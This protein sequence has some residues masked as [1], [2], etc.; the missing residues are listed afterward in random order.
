MI[1]LKLFVNNCATKSEPSFLPSSDMHETSQKAPRAP[2]AIEK[3][4]EPNRCTAER[5]NTVVRDHKHTRGRHTFF[6]N[7]MIITAMNVLM[8]FCTWPKAAVKRVGHTSVERSGDARTYEDEHFRNERV[9]ERRLRAVVLIPVQPSGSV[10][11]E[12]AVHDDL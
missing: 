6:K 2:I 9:L 5:V 1:A 11:V 12:R 10:F 4:L 8:K 3:G 7:A